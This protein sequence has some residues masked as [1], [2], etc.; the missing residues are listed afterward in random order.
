M[1]LP[2]RL[3]SPCLEKKPPVAYLE[4]V[5]WSMAALGLSHLVNGK[6]IV[7]AAVLIMSGG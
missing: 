2:G 4:G 3:P 7:T 6:A 1:H 5:E